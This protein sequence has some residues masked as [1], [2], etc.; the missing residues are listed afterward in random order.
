MA[1][2]SL[3]GV[4]LGGALGALWA[5]GLLLVLHALSRRR[6][7]LADRLAPYL[8]DPAAVR[9]LPPPRSRRSA[10][11]DPDGR[12]WVAPHWA[13]AGLTWCTGPDATVRHRL[14]RAGLFTDIVGFRARVA[15]HATSG[16]IVGLVL[17]AVS[18]RVRGSSA[19]IVVPFL[20]ICAATAGALPGL[21]LRRLAARRQTRMLAQFPTLADVLALSV[22]A[23]ESP[24]AALERICRVCDGELSAELR[25]CLA[26]ARSGVNLAIALD[27]FADRTGLVGVRRFV[28]GMVVALDRGT[29]LADVLRAQAED[30]RADARRA[31]IETAGS[32]E[33]AMLVPVV[34]LILP[35]T[36][37]FAVYPGLAVLDLAL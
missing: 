21:R 1:Q 22:G 32:R 24:T 9:A 4:V 6:V 3:G 7:D 26:E 29:P 34:F 37:V 27:R 30:V 23:G 11:T 12:R 20:V 31:L 17:G 5:T 13:S 35:V 25:R 16:A 28:D 2:A 8:P 15:A 18:W 14:Q 33:I 10:R 36:V 19:L